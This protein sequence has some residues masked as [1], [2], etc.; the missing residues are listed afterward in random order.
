[1]VAFDIG[2][3][4]ETVI[5]NQTG[6][7]AKPGNIEELTQALLKLLADKALREKMG[8]AGRDFVLKNYTWD[9]CTQ[10]MLQV[11]NEALSL[12]GN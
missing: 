10:K 4:N 8:Q 5:N 9:I 6:I 2:G 1:V 12:N 11:Y 3:I 7:L